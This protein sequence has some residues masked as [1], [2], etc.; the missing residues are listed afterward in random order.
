ME[1]IETTQ[2]SAQI[3]EEDEMI[4]PVHEPVRWFTSDLL[5]TYST[6]TN[7]WTA[8]DAFGNALDVG[9]V[10]TSNSATLY[11]ANY[12]SEIDLSG[13]QADYKTFNPLSYFVQRWTPPASEL[14]AASGSGATGCTIAQHWVTSTKPI[15]AAF[16]VNEITYSQTYGPSYD[17]LVGYHFQTWTNDTTGASTLM[18]M[19][20]SQTLGALQATTAQKLYTMTRVAIIPGLGATTPSNN[21]VA[22]VGP[23]VVT[24]AQEIVK[25]SDLQYIMRTKRAYDS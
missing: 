13:L 9:W 19:R 12:F 20:D 24:M 23:A 25:E 4:M 21:N 17:E 14:V 18:Q 15:P 10:E 16:N 11:A 3:E 1:S 22:A 5:A 2:R 6:G 7:T 8:T